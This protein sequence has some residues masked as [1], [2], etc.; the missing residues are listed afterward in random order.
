MLKTVWSSKSGRTVLLLSMK[1]SAECHMSSTVS[2]SFFPPQKLLLR[3][4]C[5]FFSIK[6]TRRPFR[7]CVETALDR[8]HLPIIAPGN[9][10]PNLR[11]VLHLAFLE[12]GFVL[13]MTFWQDYA[14]LSFWGALQCEPVLQSSIKSG[15]LASTTSSSC[16]FGRLCVTVLLVNVFW[17]IVFISS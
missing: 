16:Q 7:T 8:K 4:Q 6:L 14:T 11:K 5:R 10:P 15:M 3:S 12:K 17:N 13:S 2:L 9:N 1:L